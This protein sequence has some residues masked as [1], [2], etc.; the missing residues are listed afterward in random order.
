MRFK[1]SEIV[2]LSVAG[3]AFAG[4]IISSLYT[5]TNRNRELD[6][7]LVKLGVGILRADPK[8]TQTNGARE[9][10]I[11]IIERY[12]GQPFSEE[13]KKQL[14]QSKLVVPPSTPASPC[15]W[16]FALNRWICPES[17][18]QSK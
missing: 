15:Y 7:E 14:L 5:Y 1:A 10:A 16:D 12:S 18:P 3:L 13:A 6:I 8:E 2:A 9:W 11:Q 17:M 4:S